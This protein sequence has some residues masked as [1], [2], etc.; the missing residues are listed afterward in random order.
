MDG[1]RATQADLIQVAGIGTLVMFQY[2]LC[3][4]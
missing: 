2:G 3:G 1:G 4:L